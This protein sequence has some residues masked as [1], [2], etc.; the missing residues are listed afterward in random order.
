MRRDAPYTYHDVNATTNMPIHSEN[1]MKTERVRRAAVVA[2]VGRKCEGRL[3]I[4]GGGRSR[5]STAPTNDL[6]SEHMM[7]RGMKA[8][9]LSRKIP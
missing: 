9:S 7:D 2:F 4:G 3:G 5:H 1:V 6:G 8:P